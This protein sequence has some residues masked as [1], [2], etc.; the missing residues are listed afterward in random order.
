MVIRS[1]VAMLA[2]AALSLAACGTA[3][4]PAAPG[5]PPPEVTLATANNMLHTAE[6][7]A[8][9]KGYFLKHGVN[10][11]LQ[12]LNI[13]AE[14]TKAVE[15]GTAQF[16]GGSITAIPTARQSGLN[17]VLFA[18]YMNDATTATDD[19]ALAVVARADSGIRPGDW[20]SFVGKKVGLV[21]GGT[22]D[23]FLTKWLTKSGVDP[24]K[25]TYLNVPV[26]DQLTAIQQGQVHAIA[27]WE[28][29][30][31][32]ILAKMKSDAV[33]I[34]RGGGQLGYILGL[35][36]TEEYIKAHP[37]TVQK[38]TDALAETEAWIRAHPGEAA[39]IATHW[40]SGL[41]ASVASEAI[42]NLNF[43]PRISAC[44]VKAFADS[45]Q[46]LV[47]QRKLRQNIPAE[48][49]VTRTYVTKTQ[50]ANGAWFRD[51]KA[52]PASCKG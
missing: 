11:K 2:A 18:P 21:K 15:S 7:V 9:E 48:Q 50:Q 5:S 20:N 42:K 14:I 30:Q 4:S 36:S 10:V 31:T 27:S 12:I 45:T 52:L 34:Q 37:D 43:D 1:L 19:N 40:I 49:Q 24:K 17:L 25:V 26:G 23:E 39:V 3:S 35:E 22:G 47:E 44:T 16:G 38:L 32:L 8:K 13:G 28:P 41:D 51:L 29:Y 33:L 6:F 46:V